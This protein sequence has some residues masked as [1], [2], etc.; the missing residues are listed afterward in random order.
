MSGAGES[1]GKY[2]PRS[3]AACL[4]EHWQPPTKTSGFAYRNLG[5]CCPAVLRTGGSETEDCNVVSLPNPNVDWVFAPF[6]LMVYQLSPT[7][8]AA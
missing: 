3:Q 4:D 5:V 8:F 1:I 6:P 7:H 2:R